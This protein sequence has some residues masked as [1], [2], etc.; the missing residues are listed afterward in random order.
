MLKSDWQSDE[1]ISFLK[2]VGDEKKDH[3]ASLAMTGI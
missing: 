2:G 3:L 1:A